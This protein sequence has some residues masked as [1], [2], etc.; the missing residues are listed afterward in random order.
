MVETSVEASD[1]GECSEEPRDLCE[2]FELSIVQIRLETAEIRVKNKMQ[3]AYLSSGVGER[4]VIL[5]E[6]H[7]TL[8]LANGKK[9]LAH[10]QD[11]DWI[12]TLAAAVPVPAKLAAAVPAAAKRASAVHETQAPPQ[13][14]STPEGKPTTTTVTIPA[15]PAPPS[16]EVEPTTTTTVTI[17]AATATTTATATPTPARA[18]F[19][20]AIM[21]RA[22]GRQIVGLAKRRGLKRGELSVVLGQN[23]HRWFLDNGADVASR[24]SVSTTVPIEDFTFGV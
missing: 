1:D 6:N 24:V 22:L 13:A 8:E 15:A 21:T 12:F 9:I 4:R 23:R 14:P 20:T 18:V 17:P 2:S 5:R 10:A 19:E 11:R 16:P 3:I 7:R